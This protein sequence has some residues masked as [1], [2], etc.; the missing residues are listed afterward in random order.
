M[1][2]LRSSLFFLIY[3]YLYIGANSLNYV[4]IVTL[5]HIR[6]F[7]ELTNDVNFTSDLIDST[8]YLDSLK[9]TLHSDKLASSVELLH[10]N[11]IDSD[12]TQLSGISSECIS[13]S[14]FTLS[15][16]KDK[17]SWTFSS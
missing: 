16:L 11:Q 8:L 14:L 6:Q 9:N 3:A 10:G 5:G 12:Q 7:R 2:P 17:Q 4:D 13:D 1:I 15:Q